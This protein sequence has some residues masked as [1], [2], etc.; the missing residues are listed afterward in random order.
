M[1]VGYLVLMLGLVGA[2][3]FAQERGR[4]QGHADQHKG[5]QGRGDYHPQAPTRG[6]APVR[7]APHQNAPAPHQ[8]APRGNA[9]GRD[10]HAR[11][12]NRHFSDR[13][14]HPEAPH[15]DSGNR[16][17]GHDYGR[18]DARFHV[19]HPWEHG[20][21]T[22]G[23]GPSHVWRLGGGGPNRFWFNGNYFSVAPMDLG[24]VNGWNWNGD[25]VIIYEDP[26]H[27]GYYLAYNQRTGTYVHVL[28]MGR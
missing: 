9:P 13:A 19:D 5:E 3:G 2:S 14:G 1:K 22:L 15:V 6:P 12:E 17:V 16:W 23:F 10:D 26:D 25:E 11:Q 21:F 28:Y 18:S 4:D 20:R 27:P 24:Y 7:E 8:E